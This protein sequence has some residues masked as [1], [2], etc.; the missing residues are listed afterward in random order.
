MTL[1]RTNFPGII[2]AVDA[3][4]NGCSPPEIIEL[5][6]VKIDAGSLKWPPDTWTINP[7]QPI[8][9]YATRI[10]GITN[11]DVDQCPSLLSV[12]DEILTLIQHRS[13]VAH[14]AHI[15]HKLLKLSLP[16]WQPSAVYDTLCLARFVVPQLPSHSLSKLVTHF[17]ITNDLNRHALFKAHRACYDAVAAAYL[18]LA[19][20]KQA[21]QIGIGIEQVLRISKTG[22]NDDNPVQ[23]QLF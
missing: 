2:Y 10:H 12:K 23:G 9:A 4:S 14:N 5:S 6:I 17:G 18:F 20:I 3:E 7:L 13:I 21:K 8:K 1:D 19:L 22:L 16:D 15:D 11:A